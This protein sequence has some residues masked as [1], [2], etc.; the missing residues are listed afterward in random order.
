MTEV[1]NNYNA[2]GATNKE[3]MQELGQKKKE[4]EELELRDNTLA[5]EIKQIKKKG[6]AAGKKMR[7]IL[8]EKEGAQNHIDEA[9]RR[10]PGLEEKQAELSEKCDEMTK[11]KEEMTEVVNNYN[12]QGATNK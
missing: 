3:L 7:R 5:E 2:Q 4:F 10:I 11:L 1:V 9:N 12:A 8:E 6:K